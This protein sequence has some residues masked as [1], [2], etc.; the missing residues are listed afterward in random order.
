MFK[1]NKQTN[2][3]IFNDQQYNQYSNDKQF[4]SFEQLTNNAL[5]I[6]NIS[7]SSNAYQEL[8]EKFNLVISK[9]L[10]VVYK[11]FTISWLTNK[12]FT[13]VNLIPVLLEHETQHVD[14]INLS[15]TQDPELGK[16]FEDLNLLI[17]KLLF[18][19]Y[20]KVEVF[21]KI[22]VYASQETNTLK[23]AFDESVAK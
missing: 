9:K 8:L 5:L 13:K 3:E 11:S 4:I 21:P 12:R 1:K 6:N 15:N 18:V 7:R 19:D 2:E 14:N 22:I 16:Y 17:E 20:K 10:E 23:I